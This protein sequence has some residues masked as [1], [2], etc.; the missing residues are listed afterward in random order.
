MSW[1]PLIQV[2]VAVVSL[3]MTVGTTVFLGLALYLMKRRDDENCAVIDDVDDLKEKVSE[4]TVKIA[5]LFAKV[6]AIDGMKIDLAKIRDHMAE[7]SLALARI[8]TQLSAKND[9]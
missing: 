3:F 7:I 5:Q 2:I 8:Q 1:I 4:M 9:C 6:E